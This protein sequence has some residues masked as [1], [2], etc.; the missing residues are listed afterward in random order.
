M[1]SVLKYL[2]YILV[3]LIISFSKSGSS[4]S[5]VINERSKQFIDRQIEKLLDV[6]NSK[7]ISNYLIESIARKTPS[8]DSTPGLNTVSGLF[9]FFPQDVKDALI[10][11]F[12]ETIDFPGTKFWESVA[13]R[14]FAFQSKSKAFQDYLERLGILDKAREAIEVI[15]LIICSII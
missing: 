8:I 9:D 13:Q 1:N 12:P 6:L 3:L 4:P 2:L 5:E 11:A 10:N 7:N 14:W 15:R